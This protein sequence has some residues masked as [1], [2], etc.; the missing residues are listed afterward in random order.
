M[1]WSRSATDLL[2]L[3][4]R[5]PKAA[6]AATR[7][8]QALAAAAAGLDALRIALE[9]ERFATMDADA[10]RLARYV[11]AAGPFRQRWPELEGAVAGLP[12]RDAH[13]RVVD[14]AARWLPT[15]PAATSS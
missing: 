11:Q 4:R 7:S 14:C 5:H 9:R 10:D 2:E 6:M 3:M 13:E 15:D 1:L 12:L 8:R